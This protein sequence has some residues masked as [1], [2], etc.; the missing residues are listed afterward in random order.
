MSVSF[1]SYEIA[2]SGLFVNERGLYVTGQNISN[3][4][5]PGYV[6]QQAMITTAQYKNEPTKT[7]LVQYGLGADIQE[8]RQIRNSFLDNIYRQENTTL[9]YWQARDKTFQDVQAVI[10]EPMNSGLQDSMNQ[11]WDSWQELSKE[12]DSLTIRSLVQQRGAALVNQINHMGAQFDQMQTDLNSE[13][14]VRIDQI[15]NITKKIADLN[16]TILKN[17]VSGDSANDYRDQR[18]ALIDQ[19]TGMVDAN[20]NEMQD[21]QVDVTLGGY[22]LVQKGVSTDLYA[23]KT[24]A[25]GQFS[26]PM[27]SGTNI[28]VPIHNGELKGLLEARGEVLGTKG[29][30]SNGSPYDAVDLVYAIS[31]DVTPAQKADIISTAQ[32]AY[33]N[34]KSIGIPVNL[35]FVTY[36][37]GSVS[38][39]PTYAA[40]LATFTTGINAIP[41]GAMG[42]NGLDA[43]KAA[44]GFSFGNNDLKHVILVT[45]ATDGT[46]MSTATNSV[47]SIISDF[48]SKGIAASV[49]GPTGGALQGQLG[50]I[51]TST[52]SSYFATG[53]ATIP[54]SVYT[55]MKDDIYNNVSNSQNILPD[56]KN[57]LNLL[58]N[59]MARELNSLHEGGVTLNGSTNV[60]FF[61]PINTAYPMEMGNIQINP[62]ILSDPNYIAASGT[63]SK[64]DNTVALAIANMR[65]AQL[66]GKTGST[67]SIDDFYRSIISYVGNNGNDAMTISQNQQK[68]VSSADSSRQAITGVSMD[69]EMSTMMK[70][71]FAYDAASRVMNVIDTML[72][73]VISRTGLAGR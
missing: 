1:G 66:I 15:N 24:T 37:G 6:R 52:G 51:A 5:T 46:P 40:D 47:N 63:S 9:G 17:E 35:G 54:N 32:T 28:E 48:Q 23:G 50:Q 65:G 41:A 58:V 12:P 45:S 43:L 21:G 53:D 19:L 69:E 10:A 68:L 22:F 30:M 44:E 49:I 33:N 70:Y 26:V 20:V 36:N 18:N 38:G 4:N 71:K 55:E 31:N 2:R 14:G 42:T 8:I 34:F 7:G 3:V 29:S 72:D 57:Q 27:L 13:I 39:T 62:N 64:G 16:V 67:V 11:F 56:I 25:S 60:D 73:S 59:V 61:V